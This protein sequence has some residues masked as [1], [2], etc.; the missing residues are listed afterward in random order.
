LIEADDTILV[1]N[2]NVDNNL[3]SAHCSP[4][5]TWCFIFA[6]KNHPCNKGDDWNR[7]TIWSNMN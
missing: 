5:Y 2:N 3:L 4:L 6:N 1:A 7:L